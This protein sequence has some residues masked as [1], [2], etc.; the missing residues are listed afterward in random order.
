MAAI[1]SSSNA[2]DVTPSS[3][4]ETLSGII[5]RLKTSDDFVISAPKE[6]CFAA[7]LMICHFF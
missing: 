2:M 7:P 4:S 3:S 1:A 5:I 6:V